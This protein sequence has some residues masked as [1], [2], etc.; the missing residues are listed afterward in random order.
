MGRIGIR[1]RMGVR[2]GGG[3]DRGKRKDGMR[4]G[5]GKNMDKRGWDK[6]GR[7]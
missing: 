1:E 5:G 4:K 6:E 3:K 2:K 7:G